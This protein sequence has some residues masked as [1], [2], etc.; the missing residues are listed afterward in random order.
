MW[1]AVWKAL[2]YLG[3]FLFGLRWMSR[4]LARAAGSALRGALARFTGTPLAGFGTGCLVTA[5][6]QS[7]SLTAVAVVGLVNAGVLRLG[8]AVPVIIGAN[9]G[10]TV[11]AQLLSLELHRLAWPVLLVSGLL[12]AARPTRRAGLPLLGFGL[13]LTGLGGMARSLVPLAESR[14]FTAFL[15]GAG[16]APWKGIGAGFAATAAVQSSS[17]VAGIVLGLCLEGKVALPAAVALILGAD[18]G[19]A[20]TALIASLGMN[21]GARL[22][23]WSHFAFNLASLLLVL[24]FFSFLV[25][26]ASLSAAGPAR[27]LANAHTIYNLAG[28]VILLPLAVPA[29]ALWE[30]GRGAR[31]KK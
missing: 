16:T 7:S 15:E 29:A 9:V 20:V 23:A 13:V 6:W 19:T 2:G 18:L 4:C 31:I 1:V 10:T 21:R 5:A 22:A 14:M 8:Q 30:R 17:A 12:A 27:Q 24:P 26:L 3:V 28:A 25:A 11:T